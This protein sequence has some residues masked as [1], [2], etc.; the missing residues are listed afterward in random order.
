MTAQTTKMLGK[1]RPNEIADYLELI[2]DEQAAKRF[3]S[4]G[5][6]AQR[7]SVPFINDEWGY[8]GAK[9]GFIPAAGKK[10]GCDIVNAIGMEADH[11]LKDQAL[12]ISL[13]VFHVQN[14]PGTGKHRI[15][16]EFSGKN[17]TQ[18]EA[19]AMR[20]ALTVA[21]NDKSF[22]AHIGHPIFVGV[23]VGKD[24]LSFEGR[25]VNVRS[26]NDD[27]MLDALGNATFRD[28]LSLLT[29]A[30]PV[31]KPFVKLADGVV[32]SVLNRNKNREVFKFALGLDFSNSRTTAK[33]KLGSYVVVQTDETE[34]KWDDFVWDAASG[35]VLPRSDKTKALSLNYLVFGISKTGG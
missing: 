32:T 17:Q 18:K 13:D 31:L 9:I 19:E 7:L 2:G 27:M 4:D 1:C 25:T 23:N 5:V 11:S 29:T 15:L 3:H 10:V 28:G 20:F 24:G 35:A 34:W 22:A 6:K 33:L 21:A 14:Y 26:D 8:T 12:K 16:C 30:Q